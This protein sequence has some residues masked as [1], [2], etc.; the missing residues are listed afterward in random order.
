MKAL[1]VLGIGSPFGD[2]QAGWR[3]V[4]ILRECSALKNHV[5]LETH[6]RP[7]L[8]LIELIEGFE[9][10]FIIDAMQSGREVGVIDC[11]DE[12]A[13]EALDGYFSTHRL[14]VVEALQLA[15]AL[16]VLPKKVRVYGVEIGEVVL[17]DTLS[18]PIGLAVKELAT[19][20]KKT[21]LEGVF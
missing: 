4:D 19:Q 2:D 7:G 1:K 10:V 16:S 9:T 8:G 12:S 15:K 14:G 6:D 21:L 3:V 17:S 11:V 18:S 13:L 5:I 20:L